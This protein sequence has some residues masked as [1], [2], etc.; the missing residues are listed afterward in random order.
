[1]TKEELKVATFYNGGYP[2]DYVALQDVE[3]FF[4]QNICIPKGT[5]RHPYADVLHKAIECGN[6]QKRYQ[7]SYDN[8]LK[9]KWIDFKIDEN[10]EYRIKPSEPVYEYLW[11]TEIGNTQWMTDD[12]ADKESDWY[13]RANETRRIRQ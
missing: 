4:S 7:I 9:T 13:G 1:M 6:L 10:D 12:E 3:E 5:N 8:I 2:K 11:Y